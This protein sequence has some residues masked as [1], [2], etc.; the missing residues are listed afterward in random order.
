MTD[1]TDYDDIDEELEAQMEAEAQEADELNAAILATVR[2]WLGAARRDHGPDGFGTLEVACADIAA[3]GAEMRWGL[4]SG[5][6]MKGG[7][8]FAI[9]DRLRASV[10][11]VTAVLDANQPRS[12]PSAERGDDEK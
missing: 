7:E 12:V 3:C 6:G 11:V 2:C 5:S 4:T 10:S 9:F 1:D 8:I